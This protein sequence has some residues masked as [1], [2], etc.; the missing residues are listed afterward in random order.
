MLNMELRRT[1]HVPLKNGLR[2]AL[3]GKNRPFQV[4]KHSYD[5]AECSVERQQNVDALSTVTMATIRLWSQFVAAPTI[6]KVH[7]HIS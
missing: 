7:Q 2:S 1:A 5:K 3:D 6:Q 4:T